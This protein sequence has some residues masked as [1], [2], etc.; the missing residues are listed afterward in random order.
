MR[1]YILLVEELN[2]WVGK[3]FGWCTFALTIAVGYEI[4]ARYFFNM[5]TLWAFDLSIQMYG[6]AFMMAGAYAL[7]V[8]SHVRADMLYRKTSIKFQ[9]SSDLILYFLFFFPAC[10]A[11]T[12]TGYNYAAKAW[13]LKET[14]WNSP[15]Q[16]QVYAFKTLIPLAGILLV[17]QGVA[18]VFRCII[19][20]KE[21]QWPVRNVEEEELEKV[22]IKKKS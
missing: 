14:S 9:A 7:A 16:I 12:Y 10:I 21:G 5:P 1:F 20:L 3:G 17:L 22:L 18:E 2:T 13:I 8:Q 19:A 15:A 6:A 11:F 4:F